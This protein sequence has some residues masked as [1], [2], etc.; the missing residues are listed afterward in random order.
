MIHFY[1][2]ENKMEI[3]EVGR[4]LHTLR[5][6]NGISQEE[7]CQGICSVATLSRFEAGERRPDIFVF[8]ALF[9]RI[10]KST[11]H[12][13]ILLTIEEF[14]YFVKRRNIGILLSKKE[15][16]QAEKEIQELEIEVKEKSISL[17]QQDIYLLYTILYIHKKQK[18]E[19]GIY[20]EKAL[21]E[22]LLDVD[23]LEEASVSVIMQQYFSETEINLL[24]LYVYIREML[25]KEELS[26]LEYMI[27]YISFHITDEKFKNKKLAMAFY[28]KS[29]FY[30]KRLLWQECYDC[31][32]I[33]I[34]AEVKNGTIAILYQALEMEMECFKNK[35]V[36]KK[37]VGAQ[38][39]KKQYESLKAVLEEYK[40]TA[41]IGEFILFFEG[42]LQE[43]S[44]VEEVIRRSR[45][46]NGYSQ[47]ELSEGICT[48]ETLSRIETGKRNPTIKNFYA[49]MQKSRVELGYY[50]T[51]FVVGHFETLEKI[52]E[53][54]RLAIRKDFERIE[55][56]LKEIEAEVDMN[57]IRNQ[58]EIGLF[59]TVME[60]RLGKITIEEALNYVEELL[61]LSVE[62]IDGKFILSYQPTSTEIALFNQIAVYYR[63][64]KRQREAVEL[65]MPIYEYFHQSKLEAPEH[66]QRYF[67][68][69]SNLSSYL[70]EIDELEKSLELLKESIQMGIKYNIGRR[71]GVNLVSM[72]YVQ[73]RMKEEAY[74]ETYEKGYYLCGLFEDIRNQNAVKKHL[75]EIGRE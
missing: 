8:N 33:A 39:R 66:N 11:Q 40:E 73:E 12:M 72:G 29:C 46:R 43:K 22:T 50:N 42:M 21:K 41:L 59:R 14:D 6:Q 74:L 38:W 7:L 49:F 23:S 75:S 3:K 48:P 15:F 17:Y 9:Q 71:I 61:E 13:N 62:R 10:G 34:E 20:I 1:I 56:L 18:K 70:E 54:N 24:L 57:E 53:L 51:D 5:T 47:E 36:I 16:E 67:M 63:N 4:M 65:L 32:E 58:Q 35:V 27:S 25:G 26:L 28:L 68:I 31:C 30:K 69:I 2:G 44:L 19:A 55:V 52:S 37:D 60:Y 45:L 64:M